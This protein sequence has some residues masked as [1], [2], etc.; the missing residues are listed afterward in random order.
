MGV[1]AAVN[2]VL[3]LVE[4]SHGSPHMGGEV[5]SKPDAGC[6][7]QNMLVMDGDTRSRLVVNAD[8]SGMLVG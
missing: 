3:V 4:L 8:T 7:Y 1:R 6:E 2:P 5:A